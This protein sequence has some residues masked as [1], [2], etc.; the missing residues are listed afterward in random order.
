MAK[1]AE[2]WRDASAQGVNLTGRYQCVTI[3]RGGGIYA[4]V[5]QN[6]WDLN[7]INEAGLSSRAWV[8]YPG[9]IWVQRE[10]QGAIYSPDGFSIQFDGG[11]LWQRAPDYPPPPPPPRR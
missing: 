3:C 4:F 11:T 8:D 7:I 1:F 5:T 2:L 9:H 10:D 6:G